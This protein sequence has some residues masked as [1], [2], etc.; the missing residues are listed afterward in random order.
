[1]RIIN[2]DEIKSVL[3]KV[4][5][6][7]E[8]EAGFIAYSNGEVVVPPVGELQFDSPPGDVHIKYGYIKND[9]VYVIKIASGFPQNVD[10]GLPNGNGMMLVFN[11]KTGKPIAIL[12]DEA[13]LT[14]VRTAVAGAICAKYLAPKTVNNIGIVGT[15]LQAKMQLNYLSE[16]VDCKK[17]IVWGRS[18]A[19]F[20]KYQ[21]EMKKSAFEI[22]TTTNI[23]DVFNHCQ[24]I[25]TCT[26]SE[27]PLL[28]RV[29]PGTH[30]TAMGSDTLTKQEVDSS[31][32]SEADLVVADS[33]SQCDVRGEIHQ[34][35]QSKDI[36]MEDVLE[37]GDIISG[38]EKG[39]TSDTQITIADLTG[40]AVQDIQ[41]A[42]AVLKYLP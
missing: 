28:D 30:I 15:G 21:S 4:D 20:L 35:L 18:E 2:L 6:M 27:I 34:A 26:S 42:K 38:K 12:K 24:L 32:L 25:V 19:S 16:I 9:D 29:N 3:P 17:V 33:K 23:N 36:L 22:N 7:K 40:V 8:I 31:I 14:D 13:Y 41:I 5:L 37:L 10:R 1:M 39:R 11:Q